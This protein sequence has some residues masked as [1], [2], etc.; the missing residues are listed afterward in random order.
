[1]DPSS[2]SLKYLSKVT[3]VDNPSFLAIDPQQRYL[4]S[5]NEVSQVAGEPSG[6]VTSFSINSNTGDLTRLNQQL[7]YGTEPCYLSIDNTG[8]YV[9][10]ANYMGGNVSVLPI[11]ADG[12]LGAATDFIQHK[13]SSVDPERQEGPHAHS[14]TLDAESKH[15]FV[16]DLGLDKIFIY[17]FDSTQGKLRFNEKPWVQMKAGAGPRHLVFHPNSKYA[18]VINE[19]DSTIVAFNYNAQQATLK[20]FQT[21]STLPKDFSGPN[22]CAD[23]HIHSSGKFLYGSNRGHDSIVIFKIAMDTGKLTYIDHELTQGK[24]P[25]NFC[26]DPTETFLIV[27]NQDTGNIV[28][29]KINKATGKLMPTG[30]TAE[31]PT[32]VCVKMTPLASCRLSLQTGI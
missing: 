18:Y 9:L 26:I 5:V 19:L 21:I 23:I 8:K 16:A 3:G 17:Q 22:T 11:L 6:G 13:G 14:I 31:V 29:F 24:T 10:V 30:H 2:G 32:P 25:R 12:K 4:F 27:A 28:T 15:A 1:M 7:S 20:E